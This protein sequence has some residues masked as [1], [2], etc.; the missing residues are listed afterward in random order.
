[1]NHENGMFYA[2]F[3]KYPQTELSSGLSEG[4]SGEGYG[5][6]AEIYLTQENK[7]DDVRTCGNRRFFVPWS[8]KKQQY[9]GNIVM[10]S[11][12]ILPKMV[13]LIQRP[14]QVRNI[15]FWLY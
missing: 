1:M 15:R 5:M 9:L 10:S 7:T 11:E 14:M 6:R 13:L 8:G 2:G 12:H 4:I 3:Y